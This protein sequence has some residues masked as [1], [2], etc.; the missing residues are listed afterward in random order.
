MALEGQ[1][2]LQRR[3][4]PQIENEDEE[5]RWQEGDQMAE[6]VGEERHLEDTIELGECKGSSLKL[7][8]IQKVPELVVN[9]RM[10]QGERVKNPKVKKKVKGWSIGEM[11]ERPNIAVEGRYGRD[12][13]MEKRTQKQ[14]V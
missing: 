4:C 14:E 6:Q 3:V 13:M 7:D 9:E 2:T 11:K 8:V 1:N 12:E 5:E 10:S